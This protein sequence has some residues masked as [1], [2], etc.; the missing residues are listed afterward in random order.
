MVE[1]IFAR[2]KILHASAGAN[3]AFAVSLMLLSLY[4][5]IAIAIGVIAGIAIGA[6]KEGLDALGLG[7]PDWMDFAATSVGAILAGALTYWRM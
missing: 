3:I 7:V 4:G 6:I 5:N 2:D 1:K